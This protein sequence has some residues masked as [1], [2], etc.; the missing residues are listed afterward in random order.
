VVRAIEPVA[1]EWDALADRVAAPPYLR[2]GWVAAWWRAFGLG[3][4]HIFTARRGERLV[5]VL[6]LCRRRHALVSPTN[7]HTPGFGLLAE[8]GH[9]AEFAEQIF[10]G[11]RG[12]HRL[13]LAFVDPG[14]ED[15][16]AWRG[17]AAAHGFRTLTRTFARFA[18]VEIHGDWDAF[19]RGL[20]RNLRGDVRR[21][22]RRL[23]D[24]GEVRF[25][26]MDGL[27]QL[28]HL[29]TEA[30]RVESSGW[31]GAGGTAIASRPE[32]ERF[33]REVSAWAAER[34]KLRVAVL[35]LDG[36]AIAFE[37]G[38]EEH[39][40]HYALKAGFDPAQRA[41]SPGKL[42]IHHIL[43]RSFSS[44]LARYEMAGVEGYKLAWA[45]AFRDVALVQA[46]A[47]SAM[48]LVDWVAF[49]YGRPIAKRAVAALPSRRAP[50]PR[51]DTSQPAS[52]DAS[53]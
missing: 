46:F 39:G 11:R 45:N 25:E 18:S 36:R 32:T 51:R 49:R 2:P 21:S 19:D 26:H 38:I 23:Q 35:R 31:K 33:Y 14:T 15:L 47:P 28:D 1:C 27:E 53:A 16:G 22:F 9:S 50:A 30:F 5:G 10:A 17:A 12:A 52:G 24:V 20:S 34:G 4:L 43:E 41:F 48:G 13:S 6:P 37:L 3:T 8:P 29:L 44:G 7:W 40:V 42:L